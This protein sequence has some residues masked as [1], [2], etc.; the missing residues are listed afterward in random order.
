M[1]RSLA[2]IS[3]LMLARWCYSQDVAVQMTSQADSVLHHRIL[4]SGT[5]QIKRIDSIR[6]R[7]ALSQL[8]DSLKIARWSDSLR[9]RIESKFAQGHLERKLDSLRMLKLQEP[10]I[11]GFS[12][13]LIARKTG[14]LTEVGEKQKALQGK[15][16]D[17]YGDWMKRVRDRFDLDSAGVKAPKPSLPGVELPAGQMPSQF[18]VPGLNAVAPGLPAMPALNSEDFS[19][20]GLSKELSSIA[21]PLAVPSTDRLRSWDNNIPSLPMSIN[22]FA[23]R[24]GEVKSM[25]KDPDK[26]AKTAVQQVSEVSAAGKA[27]NEAEKLKSD[28][29]AMKVA[30]QMKDLDATANKEVT[31][32]L[33]GK[34]KAVQGAMEQVAK[35]KMKYSSLG[36]LADIKKN[37]WLPRNGLKGQSFR[38]RI[39]LGLHTG[40]KSISDTLLLDF[41]PNASYRITGRLEAGLGAIYRVRVNTKDFTFDQHDPVW[42]MSAFTVVRTFKFIFLRFEMD[43]NS[44][45]KTASPDQSS[46]RDWRW[47]FHS[48]IQTN[49]KLGK[50]WTGNIQ[51][52]YNFDSSLKDGFPERLAMRAGVQYKLPEKKRRVSEL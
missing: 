13:S 34:D 12:D 19:S 21:G 38:E 4:K 3:F 17:R 24:A 18:N 9:S 28:N 37:D 11:K 6:S 14:L 27:L 20:L 22:E 30:D 32:H 16:S 31:N 43:G 52:L 51:M 48:G 41:Y 47:T 40:V 42:G 44:F 50:Q 23:G 33:K 29:E 36:S 1:K 39:R 46:Y 35:Y 26:I 45:P 49:F 7:D 10:R 15:L 25:T 2:I 8:R 5:W